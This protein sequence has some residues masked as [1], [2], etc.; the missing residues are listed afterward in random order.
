MRGWKR[1]EIKG[2]ELEVNWIVV[3][4]WEGKW[5]GVVMER[6]RGKSGEVEVWE[7]E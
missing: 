7:G 1:E 3:E 6:E 2:M 5:Y 4:K